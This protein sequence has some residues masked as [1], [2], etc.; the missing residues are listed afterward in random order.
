M[1]S[2]VAALTPLHAQGLPG[3]ILG[4]VT[5]A[6]G[7]LIGGAVV[8]AKNLANNLEVSTVTKD[9][10]LF[11][12]SNLPIGAYSVTISKAG[13]QTEVHP[14][15]VVQAERSTT[16]NAVLQVGAVT[17]TVEVSATPMLN[18]VDNTNGYVL[19]ENVIRN[20]P[21]G[22]AAS[23]TCSAALPPS[24]CRRI[25]TD[26][27]STGALAAVAQQD[28]GVT[29]EPTKIDPAALKIMSQKD[30][31]QYFVP[32]PNITDPAV[33]KQLGYNT[34]LAGHA[35][36]SQSDLYNANIA[37]ALP[38]NTSTRT[39]PIPTL[40][41]VPPS[42]ASPRPSRPAGKSARWTT[43]LSSSPTSPGKIAPALSASALMR[44]PSNPLAP[45]ISA[46]TYLASLPSQAS[47][48]APSVGER[49]HGAQAETRNLL[50][51]Q[52]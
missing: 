8:K 33:A 40:P 7:A 6:S 20:T 2:L 39:P 17:Q 25:F 14:Q 3:T 31:G 22:T 18:E 47:T 41:A 28:L 42:T 12:A 38:S 26:D 44:A 9:N 49:N 24:R 30:G 23:A 52:A 11:Q 51:F 16:V 43:P 50:L 15:I 37:T 36:T 46:S 4:T 32:T 1:L 21:L 35:S 45:A 29:V 48:S 27:R 13:F 19:D 34:T 5:D 10:G